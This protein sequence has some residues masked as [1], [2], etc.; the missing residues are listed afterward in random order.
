MKK[1]S[2]I[3]ALRANIQVEIRKRLEL[4]KKLPWKSQVISWIF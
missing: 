4:V 3:S 1:R 2:W